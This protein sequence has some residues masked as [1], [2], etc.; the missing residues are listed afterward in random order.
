MVMLFNS[1]INNILAIS[2][3]QLY[4]WRKLEKTT[5]LLQLTEKLNVSSTQ[6]YE[7][8]IW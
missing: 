5:D 1:I 6:C 7:R 2:G 3:G 4:W 8:D